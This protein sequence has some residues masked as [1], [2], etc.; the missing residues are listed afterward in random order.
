MIISA[1]DYLFMNKAG[2]KTQYD[3]EHGA[4]GVLETDGFKLQFSNVG[5]I[6][7]S[8]ARLLELKA[9]MVE[10]ESREVK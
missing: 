9:A 8:I 3:P 5:D 2:I 10:I 6:D 4:I 7:A 1:T